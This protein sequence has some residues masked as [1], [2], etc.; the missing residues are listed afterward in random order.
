[1]LIYD[2]F[3]HADLHPGN[4][5]V[6]FVKPATPT[7]VDSAIEKYLR[8]RRPFRDGMALAADT[9]HEKICRAARENPARFHD[10]LT[11]LFDAGYQPELVFLDTGLATSLSAK[12]RENFLDL[13]EAI[14]QFDGYRAGELMITRCRTPD[15]VVQP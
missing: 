10:Y 15:L 3:V 14:A 5:L 8:W 2:N 12:N 4:I 11:I 7:L 9:I 6:S 13:F 1:M